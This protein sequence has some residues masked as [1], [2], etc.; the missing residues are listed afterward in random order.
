LVSKVTLRDVLINAV[1][2]V[3]KAG[4]WNAAETSINVVDDEEVELAN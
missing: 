3:W 2:F 4:K 1:T